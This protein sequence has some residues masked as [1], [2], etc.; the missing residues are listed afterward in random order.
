MVGIDNFKEKLQEYVCKHYQGVEVRFHKIQ[1]NNGVVLDSVT[2]NT[3]NV[4]IAPT[5][6]L[7]QFLREMENGKAMEEV[8]RE[9]I[10]VY[11][12]NRIDES[13]EMSWFTDWERVKNG[14][15][16]RVVN[17]SL[18]EDFI[19]SESPFFNYLD[20]AVIFYYD[21]PTME[22]ASI[23]ICNNH[24]D[25][26]NITKDELLS[27]AQENLSKEKF[28][29]KS[30]CETIGDM[31]GEMPFEV[32]EPPLYVLSTDSK[33]FGSKIIL[34]EASLRRMSEI[35][36][37]KSYYILPSSIHELLAT[38]PVNGTEPDVEVVRML[39][40]MVCE[41]NDTQVQNEEIL[42]TSIYFYNTASGMITIAG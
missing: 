12:S 15:T 6:Y 22:G 20:L 18:N 17:R 3:G 24:L 11:E 38:N 27:Q 23:R 4:N 26:W 21:V 32:D 16:M 8:F 28:E 14:I 1:K 40:A 42:G 9:I 7:N 19:L 39:K 5:I 2:F 10:S 41:V 36:G 33:M 37:G 25:I 29:I 13:M 35:F 34:D 30:I 31:L